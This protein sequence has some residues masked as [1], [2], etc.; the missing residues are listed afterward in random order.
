M[1]ASLKVAS[2]NV[3]GLQNPSKRR[4][5]FNHFKTSIYDIVFLQETHVTSHDIIPWTAEWCDSCYWNP[6]PTSSS[7]GVGI[8]FKNKSSTTPITISKD[9]CG[10]I[11]AITIQY[12]TTTLN[13][14]NVYAPVLPADRP[15]FFNDL[16]TYL[17][18]LYIN[19][20]GGDFNVVADPHLDRTGGT[21]S[22]HHTQGITQL[23]TILT[24]F[25]LI[26]VWR[27]NHPHHREYTWRSPHH[28]LP[29]I[30]S[31]LDR[32]YISSSLQAR[33]I[34]TEFYATTWSDHSYITLEFTL[35]PVR[36]HGHSY[37]KLN[38]QVLAEPEYIVTITAL[39]RYHQGHLADFP[40]VARWWDVVKLDIQTTT[41]AYCMARSRNH[42]AAIVNLKQRLHHLALCP[43]SSP[44]VTEQLFTDLHS[45][46][47]NQRA[48]VIIRS[49]AQIILNEEKPTK[50]FYLQEQAQQ[51]KH[52]LV[53][54]H[55]PTGV[56]VSDDDS[57]SHT[58]HDFYKTLYTKRP[59]DPVH[60]NYFLDQLTPRLTPAQALS[61]DQPLTSHELH[62]TI[63]Q[64]G[65][66]K[67]PGCD[68]LPVEFYLTFWPVVADVMTDLANYV[69]LTGG[70]LNYTQSSAILTLLFKE[71]DK[72]DLANWRPLSLLTADYKIL[73]KS[74]A[75]RI[76]PFLATLI[77][78]DQTCSV[79]KRTIHTNLY[80]LRDIITF[81]H[82]KRQPTYILSL[83]FQKAFDMIDHDFMLKALARFNFGPLLLRYVKTIYTDITSKVLNN[84][85]LT[86][87]L[88]IARGIRQGCPLSLSLYCL[89][90]ET[91]ASAIRHHSHIRGI[92]PPGRSLPVKLTQYADDTTILTT[93]THSLLQTFRTFHEYEA[94][95]GCLLNPSKIKGLAVCG[96]VPV[97]PLPI[98]WHNPDG[99]KILGIHFFDDLLHLSNFNW[100][101]VLRKLQQKLSLY[102][103]RSLSLHGKVLLLNAVALSKIWFLSSVIA[104]P[105]WAL[106]TL[107]SHIFKFLWGDTGV[108]PIQRNTLY[109]PLHEG[110]L[111]ILHP[112]RQN[113]AL[114]MKFFLHLTN[115]LDTTPWTFF[116]RYWMAST[117]PRFN[118]DWSFLSA[119]NVP[120]YNGTDPPLYYKHLR[121]I[122][123]LFLPDILSLHP[124][125][126][127]LLYQ[128]FHTNHYRDHVIPA[129]L[130]WN[131]VFARP[132]P[133]VDLW[134]NT[135]AS[136][137]TGKPHDI[138]F[139]IFHNSLPTGVRL[140]RNLAGRRYYHPMCA[141]CPH[142]TESILHIYS[143]C[144]H[145]IR[146][147]RHFAPTYALL[148][149][150]SLY[151]LPALVF[152]LNTPVPATSQPVRKLLLT[153]STFILSE[154]W[155]SRN[156]MKFE[157]TRPNFARSVGSISSNL[158]FCI[159][160]HYQ[161]HLAHHTLR[162]F[163]ANFCIAHAF[164]YLAGNELVFS[165]PRP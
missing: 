111:G 143:Q 67:S 81:A 138:L 11:L 159:R 136:Y 5:V 52:T 64:M 121:N 83:D 44:V 27:T 56:D 35:V 79:P 68:G 165:L 106:R 47:N 18:P 57:I 135:Y 145:A 162:I 22:S 66:N 117:L 30:Q 102:R 29:Q 20:V 137:A 69:F 109:R 157:R 24:A 158:Q 37:W 71:G 2:A 101:K 34:T 103:Y 123:Q 1:M 42:N 90:A 16:H 96:A 72:L 119:N 134:R 146:I 120:K 74:I 77:Q 100:T 107:E 110:G 84:G 3:N 127:K 126:S 125:T 97:L 155:L 130:Y 14:V 114:R 150:G 58:L 15:L 86:P 131:Q 153:L 21:I 60:Q 32:F 132:L 46:Q 48:G 161:H 95:S 113:L 59:T 149:H 62:H 63:Q 154:L 141:S 147:W 75:T 122:L 156:R 61:L 6:G 49:R 43:D 78:S 23:N 94:A 148:H 115:P 89:V 151:S 51:V 55:T 99:V 12:N 129:T 85:Y 87:A 98:K 118:P 13:V 36:P 139:Q 8:L 160:T 116:G 54:V 31:R 73:A 91:I 33:P 128:L 88:P 9:E 41:R 164:C 28:I 50:F 163:E 133:W 93:S 10:R 40:D 104:L 112:G 26:D 142:S 19:I 124:P 4:R 70:S 92:Y 140:H 108:E 82:H 152:S 39:I 144:P 25:D 76:R 80:L 17:S 7:C 45:L 38:T 105:N 53:A 65:L